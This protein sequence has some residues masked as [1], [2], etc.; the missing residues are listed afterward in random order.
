[1]ADMKSEPNMMSYGLDLLLLRAST[2]QLKM[3]C[4]ELENS[5][6]LSMGVLVDVDEMV[7]P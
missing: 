3:M 5:G 6:S 1:M 2:W 7:P 4:L